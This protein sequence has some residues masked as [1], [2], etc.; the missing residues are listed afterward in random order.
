MPAL[1]KLEETAREMGHSVD[2]AIVQYKKV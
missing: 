2:T 1:E